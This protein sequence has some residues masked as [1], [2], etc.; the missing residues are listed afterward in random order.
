MEGEVTGHGLSLIGWCSVCV[1]FCRVIVETDPNVLI[2]R[3]AIR[4][5]SFP[6]SL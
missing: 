3:I 2:Q 5:N 1:F 4:V 6:L